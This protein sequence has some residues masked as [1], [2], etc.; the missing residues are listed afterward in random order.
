MRR[1]VV[2]PA[3]ALRFEVRALLAQKVIAEIARGIEEIPEPR[4][5]D[6]VTNEEPLATGYHEPLP[7]QGGKMLGDRGLAEIERL[8]QLDHGFLSFAEGIEEA[9]PRRVRER[10][11]EIRLKVAKHIWILAYSDLLIQAHPL[12]A[13]SVSFRRASTSPATPTSSVLPVTPSIAPASI[14]FT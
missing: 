14:A 3:L 5:G 4:I 9:D 10:L 12:S 8:L 11:E 7:A 2:L 13:F 6:A 1:E